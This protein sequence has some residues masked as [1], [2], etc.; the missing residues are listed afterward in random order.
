MRSLILETF[1]LTDIGHIREK[2]EDVFKILEDH[3]IFSIADGMGGHK[4]GDIAAKETTNHLCQLLSKSL[5][6]DN[7]SIDQIINH[8]TMAIQE[9]NFRIYDLST[10][11][12]SFK[13][14]GTT[15]CLLHLNESKAI[16]AH[17][18]DSRIYHFRDNSLLQLTK[19]HSLIN[20]LESK[21]IPFNRK[22]YKN[23]I[24]KA[25]GT[26]PKIEPTVGITSF[27]KDDLFLMCTD[28]LSDYLSSENIT[29]ILNSSPSIKDACLNL[30]SSAKNNGS[31]DNLTTLIVK[32]KSL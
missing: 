10:R 32:I 25:I 5:T 13:G 4:A 17:V 8:I 16:Y 26:H 23:I 30:I 22:S 3:Y 21:N 12:D 19:D 24:T 15:L 31:C 11:F 1:A 6:S 2:N 20:K 28:G 27:L 14:M 7:L 9:A 18:G 29:E